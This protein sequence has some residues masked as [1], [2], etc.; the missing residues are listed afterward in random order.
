MRQCNIPTSLQIMTCCLFG[1]K[2]LSE[3]VL[4]YCQ[5]DL[6]EHISVK[7]DSKFKSFHSGKCTWKCHL[8]TFCLCVNVSTHW[9]WEMHICVGNLAIISSDNGLLPGR[10][11][12]IIQTNAGILLIGPLGTNFSEIQIEILTSS[13]KKNVWI[14]CLWH[15]GHFVSA[16][17]CWSHWCEKI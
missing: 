7:L 11:Q 5:L 16:S 15:G 4:P 1:V 3:S 2:P 9:G 13:F 10:R 8:L 14:C 6:K 12:A 17:M